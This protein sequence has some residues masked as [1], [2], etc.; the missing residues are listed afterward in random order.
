MLQGLEGNDRIEFAMFSQGRNIAPSI[1]DTD[2]WSA[3][4]CCRFEF[5]QKIPDAHSK[6]APQE[7]VC[8]KNQGS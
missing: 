6:D 2:F 5:F 7:N 8:V 3:K 1:V 4:R